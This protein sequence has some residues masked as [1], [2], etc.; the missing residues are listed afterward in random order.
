M[1]QADLQVSL[2]NTGLKRRI[3]LSL[4]AR[5][6]E[7]RVADRTRVVARE[8][9]VNGFRPGKMPPSRHP[10]S[11]PA[12]SSTACA[13][14]NRSR[15]CTRGR[16][17]SSPAARTGLPEHFELAPQDLARGQPRHLAERLVDLRQQPD[18]RRRVL[19]RERPA[20]IAAATVPDRAGVP[21]LP[22][23]P[24]HLLARDAR[25]R[26]QETQHHPPV[27]LAELPVSEP[28]QRRPREAVRLVPIP[29][30][31]VHRLVAL[32]EGAKLPDCA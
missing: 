11:P 26:D 8:A 19:A 27:A 21:P 6:F 15:G 3:E 14:R 2:E 7:D 4:P 23:Q 13:W 16:S 17:R 24:L 20:A 22:H 12:S 10:R 30:L 25:R 32:D 5:S 28:L 31:E 29:W 18:I 1:A 9:R